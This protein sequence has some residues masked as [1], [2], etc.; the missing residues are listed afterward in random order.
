MKK[1]SKQVSVIAIFILLIGATFPSSNSTKSDNNFDNSNRNTIKQKESNNIDLEP[2]L[3]EYMDLIITDI[4]KN[5]SNIYFQIQN[6]GTITIEYEHYAALYVENNLESEYLINFYLEPQQR[7]D[8]FFDYSW[9]CTSINDT[10]KVIADYQNVVDEIDESNN[11]REEN[12]KCNNIAPKITSGPSTV[13]LTMNSVEIIWQTDSLSDSRVILGKSAEKFSSESTDDEYVKN[14]RIIID[15]LEPSSVYHYKVES[16]DAN[17]NTVVSSDLNFKTVNNIDPEKPTINITTPGEINEYVIFSANAEDNNEIKKVEFYLDDNLIHTDFSEPYNYLFNS[18]EYSNGIHRIKGKAFDL[19]DNSNEK[20]EEIVINNTE[21]NKPPFVNIVSPVN[22]SELEGLVDYC[23]VTLSDGAGTGVEFVSCYV[24]D[25]LVYSKQFKT[26]QIGISLN[27]WFNSLGFEDGKYN[28]TVKAYDANRNKGSDSITVFIKNKKP[29][30]PVLIIKKHEIV[31]DRNFFEV[32]LEIKNVGNGSAVN[33]SIQD[34]F[35]LFQP[36]SDED[37]FADYKAIYDIDNIE[38]IC[39]ITPKSSLGKYSTLYLNFFVVPVMVY[40]GYK[41]MNLKPS[42]G[43]FINISYEDL[44]GNLYEVSFQSCLSHDS[45]QIPIDS[46]YDAALKNSDYLIMTNPEKLE[47]DGIAYNQNLSKINQIFSNMAYLAILKR[48]VIGFFYP[49]DQIFYTDEN[50]RDLIKK[51]LEPNPE[52]FFKQQNWAT[53][54]NPKFLSPCK[55]YLLII[56]STNVIPAWTQDGDAYVPVVHNSDNGYSSTDS[57]GEPELIVGRIGGNYT[58][59]S[60]ALETTINRRYDYPRS[61]ALLIGGTAD[62]GADIESQELFH[63]YINNSVQKVADKGFQ[64][65]KKLYKLP[66]FLSLEELRN[67]VQKMDLILYDG[68]GTTQGWWPISITFSTEPLDFTGCNP[69]VLSHS[70]NT[71]AGFFVPYLL[72]SEAGVVIASTEESTTD[73]VPSVFKTMFDKWEKSVSIGEAFTLAERSYFVKENRF[74]AAYNIYGDPKYGNSSHN[75]NINLEDKSTSSPSQISVE[76]PDYIIHP[77]YYDND[78]DLVEIPG[79]QIHNKEGELMIPYITKSIDYPPGHEI[80]DIQLINK[81]NLTT[82]TSINLPMRSYDTSDY[83]CT[84]E[85]YD[86]P[87]EDFYPDYDFNWHILKNSDGSTTLNINIY[88]FSYNPLTTHVKF[89]KYYEFDILYTNSD[90]KILRLQTDKKTYEQGEKVKIN[91]DIHNY[92]LVKDVIFEGSIL[93]HGTANFVDGLLLKSLDNFNGSASYTAVWD[94]NDF[95]CGYYNIDVILKDFNGVILERISQ[96]FRIGICSG[97]ITDF[98]INPKD[99]N[100]DDSV[101]IFVEFKNI[102]TISIDGTC[103]IEIVNYKG[104]IVQTFLN[105]ITNLQPGETIPFNR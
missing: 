80:K 49:D 51:L 18:K 91:V 19:A 65:T 22:G 61:N 10:I 67:I 41:K 14:H 34:T 73:G 77:D 93:K 36:V 8:A 27:F 63:K 15:D 98:D 13:N 31:R 42:V 71:G 88:P 101:S 7:F 66:D 24:N 50:Y 40:P 83:V 105:D 95:E 20:E 5:N 74:V 1:I 82:D 45:D 89:Y 64:I 69:I 100:I 48:G 37:S 79:G 43:T 33:I 30:D 59:I 55:G 35:S 81:T 78:L 85:P 6:I 75:A 47:L 84:P 26:P 97:I 32:F 4:W 72:N 12:W 58:V 21:D 96:R 99:F 11:E 39:N 103:I 87:I 57:F 46:S 52:V 17:N 62:S 16:T 29:I 25:T 76:I 92:G 60:K 90:V 86:G 28:I 104:E 102:G 44:D 23:W 38:W 56:G 9:E 68:H 70:C 2:D 3:K 54:L 53:K 94:S